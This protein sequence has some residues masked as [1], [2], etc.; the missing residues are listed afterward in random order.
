MFKAGYSQYSDIFNLC[1]GPGQSWC[2]SLLQNFGYIRFEYK[3]CNR[4]LYPSLLSVPSDLRLAYFQWFLVH[5]NLRIFS[6]YV[7]VPTRSQ[8]SF[9]QVFFFCVCVCVSVCVC[10]WVGGC[11]CVCARVCVCVCVCVCANETMYRLN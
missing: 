10:V 1:C 7:F 6:S 3:L 4:R 2:L 11:V 8:N 5:S 9:I